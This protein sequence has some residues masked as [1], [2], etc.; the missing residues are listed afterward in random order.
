[1]TTFYSV[2]QLAELT[3]SSE[4]RV[5]RWIHA[6]D[7]DDRL[8]AIRLGGK[9]GHGYVIRGDD[10]E[11]WLDRCRVTGKLEIRVRTGRDGARKRHG[12]RS[13]ATK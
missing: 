8:P 12:K 11:A 7:P 5:Y 6:D 3:G 1:M 13:P 2:R 4:T 9:R 10:F